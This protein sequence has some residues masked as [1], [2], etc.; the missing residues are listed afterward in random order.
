MQYT[1]LL[2]CHVL[3]LVRTFF[4]ADRYVSPLLTP[5]FSCILS[6]DQAGMWPS[7]VVFLELFFYSPQVRQMRVLFINSLIYL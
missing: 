6:G 3:G 7:K 1:V 4:I 5:I 2:L